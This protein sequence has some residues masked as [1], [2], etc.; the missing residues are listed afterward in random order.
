MKLKAIDILRIGLVLIFGG[1]GI[2]LAVSLFHSVIGWIVLAIGFAIG[3]IGTELHYVPM[4]REKW[5]RTGV[6]GYE[7]TEEQS[8]AAEIE[9]K[10]S[11]RDLN[12][13]VIAGGIIFALWKKYFPVSIQNITLVALWG[14][15]LAFILRT[16]WLIHQEGGKLEMKG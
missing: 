15:L 3:L 6:P 10:K 4:F 7:K 14:G 8:K 5:S 13:A 2:W 12:L 1:I 9:R 11:G 16:R